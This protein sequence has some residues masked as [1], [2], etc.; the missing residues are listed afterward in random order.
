MLRR[1]NMKL[2]KLLLVFLVLV[3]ALFVLP[4][5][6]EGRPT[7]DIDQLEDGIVKVSG[8]DEVVITNFVKLSFSSGDREVVLYPEMAVNEGGS[9]VFNNLNLD[10]EFTYT[11]TYMIGTEEV[12]IYGSL[13]FFKEKEIDDTLG[14]TSLNEVKPGD[15][16]IYSC[17][18]E[19]LRIL[20]DVFYYGEDDINFQAYYATSKNGKYKKMKVIKLYEYQLY[21]E[22]RKLIA[23]G[24]G[25]T[26]RGGK[27]K[28][29]KKYYVKARSIVKN[30]SK[31]IYSTW[32]KSNY[33]A[34]C[35]NPKSVYTDVYS[36][37]KAS[38]KW[39]KA[40][41]GNYYDVEAY[42]VTRES[43]EMAE[44]LWNAI[45]EFYEDV[46]LPY[47]E[48]T[49]GY[50]LWDEY[51]DDDDNW[52]MLM[53][54]VTYLEIV[55]EW[56]AIIDEYDNYELEFNYSAVLDTKKT[57]AIL[58]LSVFDLD[59][60]I[61]IDIGGHI[62]ISDRPADGSVVWVV[63]H[64]FEPVYD[65]AVTANNA[66]TE[67]VISFKAPLDLD[68]YDF[69]WIDFSSGSRKNSKVDNTKQ[70]IR[71]LNQRASSK[72]PI[73]SKNYTKLSSTKGKTGNI[74]L[75]KKPLN[76]GKQSSLDNVSNFIYGFD[77]SLFVSTSLDGTY[78]RVNVKNDFND[79]NELKLF[80]KAKNGENLFYKIVPTFILVPIDILTYKA[81]GKANFT[82]ASMIPALTMDHTLRPGK[83]QNIQGTALG[84]KK[85]E[86]R[87]SK[88]VSIKGYEL[89][90]AD[91]GIM[92]KRQK[93]NVFKITAANGV[94]INYMIRCYRMIGK[95]KVYSDFSD[96]V[97]V[98]AYN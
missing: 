64:I 29:G 11:Y 78:K 26:L 52:D 25:A 37:T 27:M 46:L 40:K 72:K 2:N 20:V 57:E 47:V 58:D 67:T 87:V 39:K 33:K 31:K 16:F 82:T 44:K 34:S 92:I 56:D 35:G 4:A 79:E 41:G 60:L 88:G 89:F 6:A 24:Y 17:G 45:Y 32:K 42:Q 21:D 22:N 38:I 3:G 30:G 76:N 61:E 13:T 12:S 59:R 66:G 19:D 90:N 65:L 73:W 62:K 53:N 51:W 5:R 50:P 8:S 70:T 54:D 71:F 15:T 43:E 94:P 83:P 80:Y 23:E 84:K 10:G 97:T 91:T 9:L 63:P 98:T 68:Y 96:I 7:I 1:Q 28:P 93:G 85:V 48:T 75:I 86:I 14:E 36:D 49:Y 69:I 95:K 18:Q 77:F 74:N 55:E 81:I